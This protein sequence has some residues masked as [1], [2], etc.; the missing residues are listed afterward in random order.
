MVALTSSKAKL[1]WPNFLYNT[2]QKVLKHLEIH[3]SVIANNCQ[4][5]SN[6]LCQNMT[7]VLGSYQPFHFTFVFLLNVPNTISDYT[8]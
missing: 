1:Q 4:I 2:P 7:F 5:I 3:F 8:A 6:R